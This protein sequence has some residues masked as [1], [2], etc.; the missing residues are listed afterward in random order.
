MAGHGPSSPRRPKA[1]SDGSASCPQ[2]IGPS[3]R[4]N[5]VEW[6][7]SRR[8]PSRP[9][10]WAPAQFGFSWII[11]V[12]PPTAPKQGLD[13]LG[14]PWILS[15]ESRLVNGLRGILCEESSAR[16]FAAGRRRWNRSQYFDDAEMQYGPSSKSNSFSVALQS[17][18]VAATPNPTRFPQLW[19]RRTALPRL[20]RRS[21]LFKGLG[22]KTCHK[23]Q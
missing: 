10:M 14:F 13:C 15:P 19:L 6:T 22:A 3:P 21:S 9:A 20:W 12:L 7:E 18:V 1:K 16:P 2:N 5:A 17:I 23:T 4:Q 11:A 8:P